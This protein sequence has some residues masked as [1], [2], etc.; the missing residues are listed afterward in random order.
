MKTKIALIALSALA[1]TACGPSSEIKT[2]PALPEFLKDCQFARVSENG[3]SAITVGRCPN[4]TTTVMMHG[5]KPVTTITV[6]GVQYEQ[7]K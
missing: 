1:L 3:L 6:D 7:K 2:Y 4:S 5:K